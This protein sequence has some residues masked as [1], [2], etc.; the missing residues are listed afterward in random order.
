MWI[1]NHEYHVVVYARRPPL[2]ECRLGGACPLHQQD[3]RLV[4]DPQQ[5]VHPQYCP[6]TAQPGEL[7][8]FLRRG[9]AL[10]LPKAD[11]LRGSL[12]LRPHVSET[13]R[14]GALGRVKP[15]RY[16]PCVGSSNP[17]GQVVVRCNWD[18][19]CFDR[20]HVVASKYQAAEVKGGSGGL[21]DSEDEFMWE[22][23]EQH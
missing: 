7:K 12:D 16:N 3:A 18:V 6:A 20:V 9:K 23:A 1:F 10:V 4:S 19:Q 15:L 22:A 21:D 5:R 14:Y 13:T 11:P 17:A 2:R 8:K